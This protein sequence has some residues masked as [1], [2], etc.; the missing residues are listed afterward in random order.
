MPFPAPTDVPTSEVLITEPT[1]ENINKRLTDIG[2]AV[3]PLSDITDKQRKA[4]LN[5]TSF[6]RNA[7]AVFDA[8]HQVKT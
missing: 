5:Q 1:T 2:V 4:S 8:Q 7:N 6:Y 3:I